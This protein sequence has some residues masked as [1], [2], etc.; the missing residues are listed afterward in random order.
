MRMGPPLAEDVI[1]GRQ[2]FIAGRGGLR[3][4]GGLCARNGAFAAHQVQGA[5]P[6]FLVQTPQPGVKFKQF[7][8]SLV[9]AAFSLDV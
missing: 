2:R 6:L 9:Q 1:L 7:H 8:E 3:E 5:Q 4:G